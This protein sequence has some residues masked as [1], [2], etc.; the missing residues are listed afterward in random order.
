MAREQRGVLL[1]GRLAT[2]CGVELC[3]H[4]EVVVGEEV[5]NGR[6]LPTAPRAEMLCPIATSGCSQTKD[7]MSIVSMVDTA[8]GV[9]VSL[10]G[11]GATQGQSNEHQ[12]HDDLHAPTVRRAPPADQRLLPARQ[13][14]NRSRRIV[15]RV[16]RGQARSFVDSARAAL[17]CRCAPCDHESPD[18]RQTATTM[19]T[20]T[21]VAQLKVTSSCPPKAHGSGPPPAAS[22]SVENPYVANAPVQR[23]DRSPSNGATRAA[24]AR[25]RTTNTSA[26]A[27]RRRAG[28]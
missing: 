23:A 2:S 8:I 18:H 17:R 10:T 24:A 19:A 5:A 6:R 4:R 12:Q 14:S 26:M 27:P 20:T 3:G 15:I 1:A 9:R 16:V 28:S 25:A 21:N 7:P 11:R 13:R 22:A